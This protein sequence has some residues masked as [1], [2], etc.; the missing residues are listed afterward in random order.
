MKKISSLF[1]VLVFAAF[2]AV[3]NLIAANITSENQHVEFSDDDVSKSGIID[4]HGLYNSDPSL[5]SDLNEAVRDCA[6]Q[7]RMNILIYLPDE[8]KR[9]HSD[10]SIEDFAASTYDTAFGEYTDGV[11]Y[12][13]DISGK[14]PAYD[15]ISNSGK[16]CLLYTEPILETIY[17]SIDQYLPSSYSSDPIDP[18]KVGK[19]IKSFCKFITDFN[20]DKPR[21]SYYDD[22]DYYNHDYTYIK[23]GKTFI[24]KSIPPAKKLH[25]L[26]I[27]DLVGVLTALIVFLVTK[28]NYKFKHKTNPRIYLA[29]GMSGLSVKNDIFQGTHTTKTR[30]DSGGGGSRGGGF[31][32][33][34]GG[35]HGGSHSGGGH[36]R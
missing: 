14:R 29:S 33:G 4:E 35:Y 26:L 32:G 22:R 2:L 21:L 5:L 36:H 20:S 16:A 24:T 10:S 31:H 11:L 1:I 17:S 23:N 30:I 18:Q 8:T 15:Y 12:Y 3:T 9:Y 28:R 25:R 13:I 6:R 7:N 19:A 27:A 34:G